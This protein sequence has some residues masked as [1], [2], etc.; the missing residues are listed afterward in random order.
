MCV[1]GGTNPADEQCAPAY[2]DP[3]EGA[4][5]GGGLQLEGGEGVVD[6]VPRAGLDGPA[7]LGVVWVVVGEVQ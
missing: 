2:R 3:V 7:A 1:D 5:A 4:A 6:G